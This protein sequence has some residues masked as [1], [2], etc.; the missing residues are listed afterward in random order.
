[1]KKFDRPHSRGGVLHRNIHQDHSRISTLNPA[2]HGIRRR[3]RKAGPVM[4][5]ARHT[6]S[7]DQYLQHGTLLAICG[8]YDDRKFRH[9][10]YY[11]PQNALNPSRSNSA[12]TRGS[13][14]AQL[15]P[16]LLLASRRLLS[17]KLVLVEER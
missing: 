11:L 15:R 6:G 17:V 2:H 4:N 7:I 14:P 13:Q 10:P 5:R 1:M 9:G 3:H 12:Q 8:D 16:I